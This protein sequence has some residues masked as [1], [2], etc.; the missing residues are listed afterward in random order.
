MFQDDI[1]IIFP[2]PLQLRTTSKP[3][4][5]MGYSDVGEGVSLRA[6]GGAGQSV[7]KIGRVA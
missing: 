3:S 7:R 5:V 4:D 1:R 2:H 6:R